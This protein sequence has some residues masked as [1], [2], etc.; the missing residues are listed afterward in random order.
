MNE[1]ELA[2][3][4]TNSEAAVETPRDI[5]ENIGSFAVFI[6]MIEKG[7]KDEV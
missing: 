4:M 1:L 3:R 6:D 5:Q 7:D 2:T